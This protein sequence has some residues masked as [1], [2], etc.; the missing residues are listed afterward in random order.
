MRG[1]SPEARG[2]APTAAASCVYRGSL[3]DA[4]LLTRRGRWPAVRLGRAEVRASLRRDGSRG[5]TFMG[6]A[7]VGGFELEG[8]L[9]DGPLVLRETTE[10]GPLVL[11]PAGW[12]PELKALEPGGVRVGVVTAGDM[13]PFVSVRFAEPPQTVLSCDA[14]ELRSA[15]PTWDELVRRVAASLSSTELERLPLAVVEG[16]EDLPL[17]ARPGGPV[18]ARVRFDVETDDGYGMVRVV[19]EGPRWSRVFFDS[20][21]PPW[22]VAWVP[23]H[24]LSTAPNLAG[25]RGSSGFGGP[26]HTYRVCTSERAL[27]LSATRGRGEAEVIGSIL[28]GQR[29]VRGSASDGSVEVTAHPDDPLRLAGDATLHV[30]DGPLSCDELPPVYG[31]DMGTIATTPPIDFRADVR[32]DAADGVRDLPASSV[33]QLRVAYRPLDPSRA[34]RAELTCSGRALYGEAAESGWLDCEVGRHEPRWLTAR[35]PEV[36]GGEDAALSVDSRSGL[37]E[38]RG[39]RGPDGRPFSLRG[40]LENFQAQVLDH[41]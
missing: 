22:L 17:R 27:A 13:V 3:V 11:G 21:S 23:T 18:Q 7:R 33:C 37:V 38:L 35:N 41:R 1:R 9:A 19:E 40:R 15:R 34:C 2:S 5:V 39:D 16:G 30:P 26:I 29:F 10:L 20:N 24:R 25:L 14:L 36:S 28:P 6:R 4:V 31:L 32:L 8:P 12:A